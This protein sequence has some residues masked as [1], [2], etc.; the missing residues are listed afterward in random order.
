MKHKIV[1]IISCFLLVS[2]V[3][4]KKEKTVDLPK[5]S[6]IL[7]LASMIQL[8][9]DPTEINLQDYVINFQAIDSINTTSSLSVEWSTL[10]PIA[11][12]YGS[13]K[14]PTL[15]FLNIF[16]DGYS[17]QIPMR[18]SRKLIV[19]YKFADETNEFQTAAIVGDMNGWTPESMSY[20]NGFWEIALP[21]NPG[22]YSYQLVLNSNWQLDPFNPT[23]KSNGMGGFNSVMKVG[24]NSESS[25]ISLS[26]I[27]GRRMQLSSSGWIDEYFVLWNNHL[28]ETTTN[29]EGVF[30]EIPMLA[31]SI[32]NS[33]IRVYALSE[34]VLSNDLLIPLSSGTPIT[35]AT[36]LDRSMKHNNIMYFMMIDRFN[37]GNEAIDK[38]VDDRRIMPRANYLGGDLQGISDKITDGYFKD[39]GVNTIWLSPI[40]QN[41]LTAYK[42]YPEP[43]RF[44]SGYHGYW[45]ISSTEIDTRFG[46]EKDLLSIVDGA[47]K[48]DKN[49][50]LDFVSNHV[51]EEHPIIKEHPNWKT[52][53]ILEDGSTNIRIWDEQRLTTWFDE[54]LPSLDFSNDSVI[55]FQVSNAVT[56]LDR[57]GFDGFRHDATKHIPETFWRALTL[58]LKEEHVAKGKSIYQVGETFGNRE[59]IGS[60]VS[61]GQMDGQF[62]FNVY[63][64][65]VNVFAYEG[66]SFEQLMNSVNAS[67]EYYGHHHLMGNISGNHDLTRFISYASGAIT[68]DD[69]P[70]EAG[71][72]RDIQ[73]ED[74]IGY[75]K[76]EL[77]HAFNMT[78]P[79]IPVVYYGDEIGMPGAND[80]DNRRMMYFDDWTEDEQS[81]YEAV[82]ALTKYRTEEIS[83]IYGDFKVVFQEDDFVVYSRTYLNETTYILLNKSNS[84]SSS[85]EVVGA[86]KNGIMSDVTNSGNRHTI[87][88]EPNSFALITIN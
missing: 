54:F 3:A 34:N 24:T 38:P 2:L 57:Y 68:T 35:S 64:D 25:N 61:S 7:G 85:Y 44:Y 15:S 16:V 51:H 52:D 41:P 9:V 79:G 12:I 19:N 75:K 47:H 40:T 48:Q 60:Y 8:D 11:T 20:K 72:A 5:D 70:K 83:L 27:D 37:N 36:A 45:P 22:S 55:D 71:W 74:P 1:L 32:E 31:D 63:F 39:L 53:L 78:I 28:L 88:L 33:A 62:D 17:Y 26:K 4:C 84:K 69:N 6:A 58:K 49:V 23:T 73:N 65:A 50:I 56:L 43:R 77:L 81:V 66:N 42:E 80:P 46:S 14:I 13:G 67:L 87:N 76:L 30:A 21:F 10:S 18:A 29:D 86:L 59:L 82:S